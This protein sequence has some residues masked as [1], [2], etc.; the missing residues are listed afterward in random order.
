MKCSLHTLLRSLWKN[1]PGVFF[2]RVSAGIPSK[3][4]DGC[5]ESVTGSIGEFTL[6]RNSDEGS[7][8]DFLKVL[9]L[10]SNERALNNGWTCAL[11]C[12]RSIFAPF[13]WSR[14]LQTTGS[15]NWSRHLFNLRAP[16][17]KGEGEGRGRGNLGARA[18]SRALIP[19]P[20]PFERLPRRLSTDVPVPV[21]MKHGLQTADH[22]LRSGQYKTR[23]ADHGLLGIKYRLRTEYKTRTRY[24]TRTTDYVYKKQL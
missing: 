13:S 19:F 7:K 17:L 18:W 9:R 1:Q 21:S 6:A 23:T 4:R 24:K 20:F 14:G 11:K 8:V 10:I 16:S 12:K 22:R 3:S 15:A 2:G 5:L